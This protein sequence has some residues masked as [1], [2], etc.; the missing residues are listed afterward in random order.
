MRTHL[1]AVPR[2]DLGL[3]GPGTLE[4][5]MLSAV[6]VVKFHCFWHF[7]DRISRTHVLLPVKAPAVSVSPVLSLFAL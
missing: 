2:A 1:S 3:S 5:L 7:A 4:F 6:S